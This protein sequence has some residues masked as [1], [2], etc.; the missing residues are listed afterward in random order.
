MIRALLIALATTAACATPAQAWWD[1]A[2]STRTRVVLDTT[3]KGLALPSAQADVVLPVRLHSGNFD[4]GVAEPGGADLRVVGADDKTPLA[5]EVERFDAINE[6]AVLW[7]R[8]PQVA[9]GSDKN[10]L[11]VYAGNEKAAAEGRPGLFATSHAAALHFSEADGP[12]QDAAGGP[13]SNGAAVREANG[14]LGGALRLTG[15]PLAFGPHPKLV[16]EPSGALTVT[17]WLK[18]DAPAESSTL[19]SLGPVRLLRSLDQ[20]EARIGDEKLGA[21]ALPGSAW[22]HVALTVGNGRAQL[23]INGQP[24]AQADALL[25][26]ATNPALV[27]GEGYKGLVDELQV[28]PAARDAGWVKLAAAAQGLDASF[29]RS[30]KESADGG[31]AEEGGHG[32]YMGI[33]LKNLT[34]DAWVVIVILLVMFFIAAAVMVTKARLV[35]RVGSANDRFLD[36]FRSDL[37]GRGLDGDKGDLA[38]SSLYRLYTTGE[39]EIAKRRAQGLQTL[40][41]ASLDAIKATLDAVQV[42]ENHTLNARMVLLTIAISGGPFLGL[43][44][45]VVGVMITFA[46]IAAAGDVNVNAIAPGIAAALLATVAGLGVAIPALFGYNWLASRIKAISADMQ[47]FVDEF[48]TRAAELHGQR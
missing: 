41:G 47:I 36:R 8:V 46:A 39:A 24:A 14:L 45:T 10:V 43:L 4:F 17:L 38:H 23:F 16:F 12:V 1:D 13:A 6:L 42:R 29:A 37:S 5:F 48:V 19:L 40:S 22:S 31:S 3:D 26:A 27:V 11:H 18:P 30:Q 15:T 21:A 44:G 7:V 2:W 32:G 9:Q 33:L 28:L 34:L 20:V 25:P 35:S